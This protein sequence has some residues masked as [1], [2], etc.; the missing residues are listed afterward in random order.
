MKEL[1]DLHVHSC[2]SDGT[3]TP[4]KLAAYAKEKGLKA[5]ALTDHDTVLGI[6]EA[7]AAGKTQ[8]IEVIPGIEFSTNYTEK[9]IHVLGLGIDWKDA[10]F[11]RKLREFQDSRDLRNRKMIQRMADCGIAITYEKMQEAFPDSTWTRA[12]F[13]RYLVDRKYAK[14]TKEAFARYVG[15]DAPCFVPREKVT[16]FQAVE[17]IR[18]NGGLAVLAHPVLYHLSDE[19]LDTLV[20]RLKDYGLDGVEAIYSTYRWYDET[21]IKALARKYGLSITGG[22]DFHGSNK[23]DIDLG[24]GRGNLKISYDLWISLKNHQAYC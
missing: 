9:D 11:L 6:D 10:R 23:P 3:Y 4:T 18:E 17:L 21:H 14:S 5:F 1:T 19:D 22:S 12:N 24:V 20:S 15:D 8:G 16:P 13:A 2:F 7:M